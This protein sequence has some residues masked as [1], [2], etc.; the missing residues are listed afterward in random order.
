MIVIRMNELILT[1]HVLNNRHYT[2]DTRRS[3]F[4][5]CRIFLPLTEQLHLPKA[6]FL[7][8]PFFFLGFIAL[9]YVF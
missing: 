1:N 3:S 5:R 8:P 7:A 2:P 9:G 4:C 6:N